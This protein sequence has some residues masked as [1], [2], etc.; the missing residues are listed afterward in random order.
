MVAGKYRKLLLNR[1]VADKEMQD[2]VNNFGMILS[3]NFN[4]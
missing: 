3:K 4:P 1:L 2:A